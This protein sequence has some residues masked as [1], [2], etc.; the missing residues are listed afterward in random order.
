LLE[1]YRLNP[2][3]VFLLEPA[4][5]AVVG[6]MTNIDEHGAPGMMMHMEPHMLDYDPHSGDYG[7]GFFGCSLQSAS[8][9]VDHP[10]FGPVCYLWNMHAAAGGDGEW[11]L[12]RN[13]TTGGAVTIKPVDLYRRRIFLEPLSLYLTLDVGTFKAVVL[14]LAVKKLSIEFN[15]MAFDNSTY[16]A[17]RLRVQ[18]YATSFHSFCLANCLLNKRL[19]KETRF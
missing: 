4:L 9:F 1:W 2:D 7:L 8:Y 19:F 11:S 17:R 12:G 3:D 14:D 5:G 10:E 16:V 6:Q 13:L 15:S 18:R